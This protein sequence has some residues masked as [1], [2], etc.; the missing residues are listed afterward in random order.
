MLHGCA[1]HGVVDLEEFIEHW[2]VSRHIGGAAVVSHD[3]R[4]IR[5]LLGFAVPEIVR[6]WSVQRGALGPV[7]S[8]SLIGMLI[9]TP[10]FG[11]LGDRF[12]RKPIIIFCTILVAL[13][14]LASILAT[15]IL[16]LFILRL[17]TGFG[18]GGIIPNASALISEMTGV[19]CRGPVCA[20]N[21]EAP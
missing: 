5:P 1:Q 13:T 6:A 10:V 16:Q 21:S 14:T 9:A 19:G 12:G 20:S 18:L 8:A 15:T 11:Y 3:L 17:V 2:K 7:L 4:R